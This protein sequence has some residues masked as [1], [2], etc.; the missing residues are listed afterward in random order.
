MHLLPHVE[1]NPLPTARMIV[2]GGDNNTR[3]MNVSTLH[4]SAAFLRTLRAER[5]AAGKR[6]EGWLP[7]P[8]A[9]VG[10]DN[11]QTTRQEQSDPPVLHTH[12]FAVV[13]KR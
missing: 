13:Y 1:S 9:G 6:A 12:L 4:R 11:R 7:P 3:E 8:A 10:A 5:G 2:L